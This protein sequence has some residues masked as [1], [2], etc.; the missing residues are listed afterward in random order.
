[1]PRSLLINFIA[2]LFF[3]PL[4]L[5]YSNGVYAQVMSGGSFRIESDSINV[6][7]VF[8]QSDLYSLEDTFGEVA[9]GYSDSDSFQLRAGYQQMQAVSISM[10]QPNN[11]VMSPS[12][13]GLTG[14]ES[15]GSTN[16]VVVT[17]NPAGYELLISAS[18][19]P[20]MQ[21]ENNET[22]EDYQP[23][24]GTDYLFVTDS[25]T[26]HFGFS[27]ESS[28][29][30]SRFWN[31]GDDTCG[32]LVTNTAQVCWDGLSTTPVAIVS[33]STANHPT[34]TETTIHFRVGVGDAV[35][36]PAGSYFATTTLTAVP[37]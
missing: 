21:N 33:T 20:A 24:S 31:N 5:Y 19:N 17:D 34:G 11:V 16:F 35:G 1:M 2:S 10:T 14:G 6:G 18:S 12:I 32:I 4:V 25:I 15:N 9:T 3:T 7:G 26:S 36:Q 23:S 37:L 22:I 28:D 27:V 29:A 8:S 30:N 13:L